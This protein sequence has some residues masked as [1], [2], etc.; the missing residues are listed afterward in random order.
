MT[1]MR[2]VSASPSCL[3]WAD[4]CGLCLHDHNVENQQ[5]L[6]GRYGDKDTLREAKHLGM[7]LIGTLVGAAEAG[8]LAKV[9]ALVEEFKCSIFGDSIAAAAFYGHLEICQFLAA[10]QPQYL[11][12]LKP[13]LRQFILQK[14]TERA[15]SNAALA[16]HVET[17]QFWLH[18]AAQIGFT[19]APHL[20]CQLAV[21]AGRINVLQCLQQQGL[22]T[23]DAPLLQLALIDAGCYCQLAVAQW[24][25]QQGAEWP[26]KLGRTEYY[27]IPAMQWP[28]A[29]VEWARSEGCT[30][31]LLEL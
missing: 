13:D 22:F 8:S 11:L 6:I 5:Q 18:K 27:N 2:A 30:S 21:Q 15:C 19:A 25:R 10:Q 7:L 29:A 28:A 4:S 26:A 14:Q 23:D 17:L 31:Q 24:L 12:E 16:G 3:R 9:Q 20:A 1:L